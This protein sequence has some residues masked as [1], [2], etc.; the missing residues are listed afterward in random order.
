MIQH[1]LAMYDIGA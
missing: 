1:H